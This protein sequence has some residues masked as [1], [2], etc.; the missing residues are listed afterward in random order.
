[1]TDAFDHLF[2]QARPA[3]AQQR[4]FERA[5]VLA[6]SALV[7]LGRRTISG[8]LCASGQ[9]FADWSAA[10]RLFE[11]E[12]F[13]RQ[14]LFDPARRAVAE[15]LEPTAPLVA[16]MDD[17]LL[18][19][20]GRKA[21]GAGW[22]RDPLGPPFCTNFVWGQRFLQISA[23]LPEQGAIGRARG[24]PVDLVH[25]PTPPRP[26][27]TAPAQ[28]WEEYRQ[29]QRAKKISAV[30]AKRLA[31]LRRRLNAD[32]QG[33]GRRLIVSVD[34]GFT[35]QTVFRHVP[36]NTVLIGRIRKDARLRR[37]PASRAQPR[38]GRRPWYGEPLPTPEQIRQDAAIPWTD[39]EAFC[40]GKTHS[41]Q[42]KTLPAVRWVGTGPR[43]VRVVIVRPLAYRPRKGAALLYRDPVY[44]L[45]TDPDLPLDQLMQAYLWRW[46]IELNFRDEKTLLGTGEAQVRTAASVESV[47]AL[48]VA[49]YA[50]MLLAGH[51]FTEHRNILPLPK[52]RRQDALE[53]CSTARLQGLLRTQLWATA[54]GVNSYHFA[55]PR[56]VHAKPV[57]FENT[58]PDAVC[59]AFR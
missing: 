54:M 32:P 48:I 13:D 22:R 14:A 30:G 37:A 28:D 50:F 56:S 10:Y 42:V 35:N 41:F 40:A 16:M 19:K 5:R 8:L 23:A 6:L 27:K 4:T 33:R 58:L 26:R 29:R 15:A 25:A 2:G 17:T 24:V 11:K 38:R 57:L 53:R 20:R 12:R 43:D 9:Q 52:W 59:H 3:F 1:M 51:A 36:E 7:G 21:H 18:R 39:V 45:C 55:R 44:L 31:E 49:S 47:P 34:G 46:E